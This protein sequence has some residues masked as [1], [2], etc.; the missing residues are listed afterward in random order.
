MTGLESIWE[1]DDLVLFLGAG[2]SYDS[3]LPL[4]DEAASHLVKALLE[5]IGV[6]HSEQEIPSKW[7]RFEVVVDF[8]EQYIPDA[9][10]SIVNTFSGVGLSSTHQ[11]LAKRS[12]P[13]WLWLTTN[14]DDQIERA[15]GSE[16]QIQVIRNRHQ[17]VEL[18]SLVRTTPT[19]VKLHGDSNVEDAHRDLGASIHQILRAFPKEATDSITSVTAGRPILFIGYSARDPDL[20]SLIKSIIPVASKVIWIDVKELSSLPEDQ[21]NRFESLLRLSDNGSY[22]PGGANS[23]LEKEPGSKTQPVITTEWERLIKGWVEK[24]KARSLSLA[25]AAICSFQGAKALAERV[26]Q[27]IPARGTWD[28]EKLEIQFQHLCQVGTA[29]EAEKLADRYQEE[30]PRLPEVERLR[31]GCI[32]GDTYHR[33]RRYSKAVNLLKPLLAGIKDRDL[34]FNLIRATLTLGRDQVFV[35]GKEEFES[36]LRNL[37]DSVRMAVACEDKVL[38]SEARRWLS[39]GLILSGAYDEGTSQ[40]NAAL[41]IQVAM[42]NPRGILDV[43]NTIATGMWKQWRATEALNHYEEVAELADALSESALMLSAK[44]N[45]AL[46]RI[47]LD[48]DPLSRA[49]RCLREVE[50]QSRKNAEYGFL[51]SA[52]MNRGYARIC[53]CIWADAI[54][55]LLTAV[56]MFLGS[57]NREG[58]GYSLSLAGW[59]QLRCGDSEQASAIFERIRKDELIPQGDRRVYFQ[60]LAYALK[61]GQS[62]HQERLEELETEFK[63]EHEVRFQ[64]LLFMLESDHQRAD[65]SLVERFA[66]AA[67][68]AAEQSGFKVFQAVLVNI[69]KS[70]GVCKPFGNSQHR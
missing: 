64:L 14:F 61:Y 36:G 57:G 39:I 63:D 16:R 46:C 6:Q 26:L 31:A 67:R 54:G 50:E 52:L 38:E 58:A 51:A 44:I 43:K 48:E 25:A 15:H 20:L 23:V 21:R 10:L 19:L 53:A 18:V 8:L 49:D 41:D 34:T 7:P 1:G 66:A 45:I 55:Y 17:M 37:Q 33:A 27:R 68:K 24:Q 3:G 22:I 2:A 60:M 30:L 12:K 29:E 65:Q 5:A 28:A 56:D 32:L 69:L 40:A 11:I 62:L 4:G 59:A 70:G 35:G 42:G 47:A 9:A 13:G